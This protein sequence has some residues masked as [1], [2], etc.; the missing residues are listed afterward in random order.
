MVEENLIANPHFAVAGFVAC[1]IKPINRHAV[2]DQIIGP[3]KNAASLCNRPV[4]IRLRKQVLK[5]LDTWLI[6][7]FPP[8][9]NN[10][11]Q[12]KCS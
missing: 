1:G 10:W 8:L 11:P 4:D 3:K 6:K 7:R 12:E 9:P 5:C 2:G